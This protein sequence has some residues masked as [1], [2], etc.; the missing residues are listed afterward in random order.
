MQRLIPAG[1]HRVL[2]RVAYRARHQFRRAFRQPIYGVNAVLRDDADRVLLVRHSYGPV[3]W[4][5]PGGG[6]GRREEP[7]RAVRREVAE[8]LAL[9]IGELELLETF[10]D[11]LSGAPHT[12]SLFAG[13]ALG[14][15]R[16]DGREVIA[17]RF[18]STD[19]LPQHVFAPARA[20]LDLWFA[21]ARERTGQSSES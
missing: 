13:I 1:L 18:F 12:S 2:Y 19:E 3:Y 10:E 16:P 14:E 5:L 17:A 11:V 21:I 8:E 15:P 6:H 7:A 9:E 20:R 4:T